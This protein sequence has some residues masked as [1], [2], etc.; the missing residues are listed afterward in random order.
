M[1]DGLCLVL[2]GPPL[3]KNGRATVVLARAEIRHNG[4]GGASR[5]RRC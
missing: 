2:D 1:G 5:I 3:L 4:G